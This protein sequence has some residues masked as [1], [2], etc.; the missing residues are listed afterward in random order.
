MLCHVNAEI[1]HSLASIFIFEAENTSYFHLLV[2]ST[3]GILR[4][5]KGTKF[6]NELIK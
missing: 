4:V 2:D 3:E 6:R 1:T 5:V